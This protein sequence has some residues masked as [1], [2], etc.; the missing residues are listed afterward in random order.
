MIMDALH[1]YL[2]SRPQLNEFYDSIAQIGYL[3]LIGGILREYR[4]YG[5]IINLRD[6]D[7]II[8]VHDEH[9]WKKLLQTYKM[10]TNRF[11]GQKIQIDE[12]EV[13]VWRIENT[14]AYR[15]KRVIAAD[16]VSSLPKTVFLNIDGIVYDCNCN[17]WMD[18]EYDNAMKTRVLDVVLEDNPQIE[19]NL[20]RA[21]VLRKRYNMV[22]SQRLK[23]T[24][25]KKLLPKIEH[26]KLEKHLQ[27]EQIRRYGEEILSATEIREEIYTIFE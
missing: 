15:E 16:R 27:K 6:I 8:D 19:L 11:G 26:D 4:D 21:M 3:Y 2:A 23:E 9:K 5:D 20:L 17:V 10:K 18:E 13:D 22:Y 1:N 24:F 7:M 14:W 12:I 25:R